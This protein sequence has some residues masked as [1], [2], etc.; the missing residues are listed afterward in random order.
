MVRDEQMMR[1]TAHWRWREA[2]I[3][4]FNSPFV[5]EGQNEPLQSYTEGK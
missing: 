2:E 3:P 5:G 1:S 4:Q